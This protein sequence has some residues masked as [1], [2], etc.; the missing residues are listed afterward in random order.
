MH[1]VRSRFS[2]IDLPI[3]SEKEPLAE[4]GVVTGEPG[5]YFVGLLFLY[6]ASSTMIHG[7][8]RDARHVVEA[9]ASRR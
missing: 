7:V 4:R 3:F 9:I 1:R 8:D 5:L 2:W 6:A